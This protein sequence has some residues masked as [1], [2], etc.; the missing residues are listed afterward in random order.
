[1]IPNHSPWIR[2]LNRTRP[3]VPLDQNV[4]A[5]VVIVGGGIAGVTTAFFALR[6][7]NKT[8]ILL[9]ADKIAHGAT[10]HNAGQ[11]TS[12]LERPISELVEKFG[13]KL[14]IEGQQSV[15][16]GW[17]L[18]DQIINEAG[19]QV[20]LYRFTGYDGLS[21]LDQV[22]LELKNNLLRAEGG[23]QPQSVIVAEE[24]DEVKN[25]PTEYKDLYSVT[26]KSNLLELLETQNSD[27]NALVSYPKGCIN[28]A[29]FSEE[30]IGYLIATYKNRFSFYEGSPVKTVRLGKDAGVLDVLTHTVEGGRIVLCTNGFE[31]FTIVNETGAKIDPKFHHLVTGRI[32][33][34]S[35]YIE[36][37][38]N[39]PTALSYF[40]KSSERTGDPTGEI[41]FLM[42]R[43]PYEHEGK[44]SQNLVC[45]AGPEKVLPNDAMY[46]REDLCGED[47]R[48]V[49]DDF[50]R[51]NYSKHP[52]EEAEYIF[53]WHGLMGYTP[54]GIRRVGPE[55]CNPVLM[56]N[57]GCNGVGILPSIFGS[58]RISQF[59]NREK[60][61]ESIFDP[62]DQS[63]AM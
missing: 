61:E 48:M 53:C 25:I 10:G 55:P 41:Y 24:W 26:P 60:I 6:N 36:P 12:Y 49:I 40:S 45:A 20:P 33:Y 54:S 7:T 35:G 27:Y 47:T 57:L 17:T 44:E 30:L 52:R 38:N 5:D 1:M 3:V 39:P 46:S 2:Q 16:S 63:C 4:S 19:L 28:S 34:M 13:L 56:Y 58:M 29:F 50:L 14:A 31:N 32:G 62:H 59:I 11:V 23:L 37:I 9:E 42:T 51:A 18:L 15:E 21:T 8:V 43:R 22:I